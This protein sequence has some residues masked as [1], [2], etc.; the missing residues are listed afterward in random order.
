MAILFPTTTEFLATWPEEAARGRT[1][2][3]LRNGVGWAVIALVL[4]WIANWALG[5]DLYPWSGR[6]PM[7]AIIFQLLLMPLAGSLF[8]LFLWRQNNRR[9]QKLTSEPGE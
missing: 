8:A 2:F 5:W 6:M 9:F 1:S 3:V 4:Y 7:R